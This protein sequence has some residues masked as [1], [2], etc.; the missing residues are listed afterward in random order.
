M[1][2]FDD[3]PFALELPDRAIDAESIPWVPFTEGGD[4]RP[5]RFDLVNGSWVEITRLKA[6]AA[7]TRH[8]HVGSVLG[9]CLEGSWR[10][11]ERDWVARPGTLVFEPPG[12]VHT[13]ETGPEGMTTLFVINGSIQYLDAEDQL[14][15]EDTV[16]SMIGAY[17]AHCRAIGA[18]ITDLRF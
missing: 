3:L 16:H 15:G 8:R 13:L 5:L 10:Y 7:V 1:T 18:E 2:V 4:F 14:I 9:F 6:G 11:L 12:D 17:V